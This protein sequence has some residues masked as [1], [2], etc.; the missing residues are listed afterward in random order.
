MPLP[1]DQR[2]AFFTASDG[3]KSNASPLVLSKKLYLEATRTSRRIAHLSGQLSDARTVNDV[4][5]KDHA[6]WLVLTLRDAAKQLEH[7]ANRIDPRIDPFKWHR[8]IIR[9]LAAEGID[10]TGSH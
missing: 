8:G 2:S 1:F 4:V 3:A 5:P 9:G 7:I 6:L 10:V